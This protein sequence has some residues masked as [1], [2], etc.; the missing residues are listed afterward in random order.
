LY[1]LYVARNIGSS[2]K[3]K[4]G[5]RKGELGFFNGFGNRRDWRL[6]LACRLDRRDDTENRLRRPEMRVGEILTTAVTDRYRPAC[7][8]NVLRTANFTLL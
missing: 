3:V 7:C 2:R 6:W 8:S 4:G 1:F 5:Q